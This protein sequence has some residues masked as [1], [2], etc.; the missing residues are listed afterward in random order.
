MVRWHPHVASEILVAYDR[1]LLAAA[2]AE[3]LAV[4]SP[5]VP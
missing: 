1:E 3:G 5:G 2:R 4:V